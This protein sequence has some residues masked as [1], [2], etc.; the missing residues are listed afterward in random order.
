MKWYAYPIT[1]IISTNSS[2][3]KSQVFYLIFIVSYQCH[4]QQLKSFPERSH[5]WTTRDDI[6]SIGV[7]EEWLMSSMWVC[8]GVHWLTWSFVGFTSI[9]SCSILSRR[10]LVNECQHWEHWQLSRSHTYGNTNSH[11]SSHWVCNI[12][13]ASFVVALVKIIL[14]LVSPECGSCIIWETAT[15]LCAVSSLNI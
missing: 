12:P 9:S 8:N 14:H 15:C 7:S 13:S 11:P 10:A 4:L 3:L 5:H 1:I 2:K 6:L